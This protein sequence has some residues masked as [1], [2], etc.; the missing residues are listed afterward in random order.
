MTFVMWHYDLALEV[1]LRTTLQSTAQAEC[2]GGAFD[3]KRC[4]VHFSDIQTAVSVVDW[5]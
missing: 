2:L 4:T 5:E 1:G 3:L